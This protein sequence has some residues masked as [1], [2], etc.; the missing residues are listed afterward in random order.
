MTGCVA[1][2]RLEATGSVRVWVVTLPPCWRVQWCRGSTDRPPASHHEREPPPM[3][4]IR[5]DHLIVIA[6]HRPGVHRTDSPEIA[7]WLPIIGPTASCLA[8][9]LAANARQRETTFDTRELPAWW[10]SP[11]TARSCGPVWNASP[12]SGAPVSPAP[13]C[14]HPPVVAGAHRPPTTPPPNR[15][16]RPLPP[17]G[18]C[19][20][21]E[22]VECVHR[23]APT[24][25]LNAE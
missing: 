18:G 7:W 20:P 2:G 11:G 19:E 22:Q 16:G 3:S 23:P 6:D 12:P 10:A 8:V 9:I 24:H 13:A 21:S 5:P 17:P 1:G 14:S 25:T 15:H 4:T